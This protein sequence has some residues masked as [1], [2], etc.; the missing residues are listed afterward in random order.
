MFTYLDASALFGGETVSIP[1]PGNAW[2]ASVVPGWPAEFPS[3]EGAIVQSDAP[4]NAQGAYEGAKI[5]DKW[6]NMPSPPAAEEPADEAPAEPEPPP[7]EPEPAAEPP[8]PVEP[9][10]AAEEV[11]AAQP[12]APA[13]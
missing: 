3:L 13:E 6:A 5:A 8:P 10:A 12:E 4:V 7:P 9:E 11:P 2:P 1:A